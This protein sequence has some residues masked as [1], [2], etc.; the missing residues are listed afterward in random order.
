MPKTLVLLS[1]SPYL[2]CFHLSKKKKKKALEYFKKI[3][4]SFIISLL[5]YLSEL[6]EPCEL[7]Y[8]LC[9]ITPS[10]L[11]IQMWSNIPNILLKPSAP[12]TL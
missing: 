2:F 1:L 3:N 7:S 10:A 8:S 12:S 4:Q 9:N 5:L 6:R 11:Q